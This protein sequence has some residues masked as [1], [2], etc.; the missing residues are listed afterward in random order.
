MYGVGLDRAWMR[1]PPVPWLGG[2]PDDTCSVGNWCSPHV[3]AHTA[4]A[5]M[6]AWRACMSMRVGRAPAGSCPRWLRSTPATRPPAACLHVRSMACPVFVPY[7]VSLLSH[8]RVGV[9]GCGLATPASYEAW[10]ICSIYLSRV[11][12]SLTLA[13]HHLES[14]VPVVARVRQCR[15]LC[16]MCCVSD[17]QVSG[18][19]PPDL[20]ETVTDLLTAANIMLS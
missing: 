5:W 9:V 13:G 12:P 19:E 6:R 16:D 8:V 20:S 11:Y 18:E 2:G 10:G 4:L 17:R 1:I 14:A 7:C 15:T 3:L